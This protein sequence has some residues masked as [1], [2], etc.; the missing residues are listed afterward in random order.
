[1]IKMVKELNR[2]TSNE[3][4]DWQRKNLPGKFII[5]DIDTWPI[6]V[7]NSEKDYEPL[8]LIELKRSFIDIEKW[9]PWKSDLPNYLS[10]YRLSVKARIPLI[11]LYFKKGEE[12]KGESKIAIFKINYV[13]KEEP[14]ISFER[15]VVSA[16]KFKE[17]FPS[18]LTTL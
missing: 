5:Q 14:W 17:D 10:L 11:V 8:C 18:D 15:R 1:M 12:I 6:V 13:K 3:F 9:K 7:S 2:H 16:N 4:H